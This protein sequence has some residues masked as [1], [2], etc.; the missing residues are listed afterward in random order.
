MAGFAK[1]YD[2]ILD[3]SVW[4]LPDRVRLVWITMLIMSDRDGVVHAS[5]TGLAHRSRVPVHD[6]EQALQIF[7]GPDK[8]SRDGTSGERIAVVPGGWLI[9]NKDVYR[10]RQTPEQRAVAE[11][12][13]RLRE[14]RKQQRGGG[15]E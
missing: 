8:H 5:V 1:L 12:V 6:T 4:S 15:G 11:R 14:R 13:R 7:L 3:S 10:D 9:L 2:V